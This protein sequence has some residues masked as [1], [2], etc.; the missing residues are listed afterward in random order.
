MKIWAA[1]Y[2]GEDW[3]YDVLGLGSWKNSK[4]LRRRE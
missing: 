1:K 4:L 2:M 3:K